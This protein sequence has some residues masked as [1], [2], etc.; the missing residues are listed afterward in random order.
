MVERFIAQHKRR[1]RKR[2]FKKRIK[3]FLFFF[4]FLVVRN[5][6]AW[7]RAQGSAATALASSL[8]TG[9][10]TP[11]TG[12]Y[13]TVAENPYSQIAPGPKPPSVPRLLP[14]VMS[15]KTWGCS[16]ASLKINGTRWPSTLRPADR[17][18]SFR[19]ATMPANTGAEQEVPSTASGWPLS[20]MI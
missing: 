13:P 2:K 15:V 11:E 5:I 16:W 10:P 14:L 18:I 12:S 1:K 20:T 4:S 17:R 19:R 7:R 9:L 6:I 3:F 8:N